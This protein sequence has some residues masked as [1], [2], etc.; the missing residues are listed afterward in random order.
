MPCPTV[1]H[2]KNLPEPKVGCGRLI[3]APCAPTLAAG[4]GQNPPDSAVSW[5][6][7]VLLP[8]P[9]SLGCIP[10]SGLEN[11]CLCQGSGCQ[12]LPAGKLPPRHECVRALGW[13]TC[14]G[15][16]WEE[17]HVHSAQ[18]G[19]GHYTLWES[20]VQKRRRTQHFLSFPSS[21]I[22]H[23]PRS[24][25]WPSI[26]PV[27]TSGWGSLLNYFPGAGGVKVS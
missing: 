21:S 26:N 18:G 8:P 7:L 12:V 17:G 14:G 1:T 10:G 13:D 19:V 6:L 25:A 3:Y 9:R 16:A 2:P 27:G 4:D 23:H 22:L 11:D 5:K 15:R 24:P 20:L